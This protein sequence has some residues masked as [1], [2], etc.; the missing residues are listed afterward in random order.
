MQ[1]VTALHL[2]REQRFAAGFQAVCR[3]FYRRFDRVG[4]DLH[5]H[6]LQCIELRPRE[7]LHLAGI[8]DAAQHHAAVGVGKRGELV[9]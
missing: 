4:G 6:A 7:T 1:R 5:Q 2:H 3:D 9:G 8:G